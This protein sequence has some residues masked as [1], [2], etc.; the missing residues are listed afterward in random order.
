M[1]K[2]VRILIVEDI[3]EDIHLAQH[4]I[5]KIVSDCEFQVVQ[6]YD[7]FLKSL[8]SFQPDVIISD[9]TLPHFVGL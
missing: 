2:P 5:C 3:A 8:A 6:T 1:K 9:Y 7:E 4:E